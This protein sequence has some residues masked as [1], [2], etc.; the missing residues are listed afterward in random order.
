[1][2]RICCSFS[3]TSG[4]TGKPKGNVH[5]SGGYLTQVNA[6]TRWVFDLKDDDVFWCTADVGWVTGHSYIVYGPL[7]LGTTVVMYE[8]PPTGPRRI[9]SGAS[10]SGTA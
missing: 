10:S 1:M 4:T 7:S 9:G 2:P 3:N 5:T 6:T 8:A